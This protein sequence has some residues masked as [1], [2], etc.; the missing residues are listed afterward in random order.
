M[1]RYYD[2]KTGWTNVEGTIESAMEELHSDGKT[3]ITADRKGKHS[4][5]IVGHCCGEAFV[6]VTPTTTP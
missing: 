3:V 5:V 6:L 4:R 1:I 2:A